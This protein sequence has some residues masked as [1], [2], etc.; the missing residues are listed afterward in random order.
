MFKHKTKEYFSYKTER[1][2]TTKLLSLIQPWPILE[3]ECIWGLGTL[4]KSA[5][6]EKLFYLDLNPGFKLMVC[7]MR[8]A[9]HFDNFAEH[10]YL[11]FVKFANQSIK[12]RFIFK[13]R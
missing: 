12:I 3:R 10:F 1:E 4:L 5:F 9:I 8:L 11:I 6:F 13:Q 2:V 7:E